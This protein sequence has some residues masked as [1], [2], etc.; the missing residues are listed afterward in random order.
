MANFNTPGM[1]TYGASWEAHGYS[2][3]GNVAS[4]IDSELNRPAII[5]GGSHTVFIDLQEALQAFSHAKPEPLIFAVNDVGMFLP[6]VDHWVSLHIENLSAWQAVR[7]L[8]FS[9]KEHVHTYGEKNESWYNWQGL[10]PIFAL[11]GYFAM[12][13]AWIMGCAPI[14]LAG[15]PGNTGRRFF[16]GEAREASHGEE[17]VRKQLITE[18]NRLPEFRYVVRSMSGWTREYFN[19]REGRSTWL[20]LQR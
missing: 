2:G 1:G 18:M 20:R 19:T 16:E 15:C 5:V 3:N 6:H 9:G 14:V 10:N 13:I 4:L 7:W 11:S 8:H 17:N 12:Q